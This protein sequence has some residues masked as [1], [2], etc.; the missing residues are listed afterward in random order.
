[1]DLLMLSQISYL[2]ISILSLIR[3]YYISSHSLLD[4]I[5]HPI[6]LLNLYYLTITTYITTINI[7]IITI[8][9]TLSL[10]IVISITI[11]LYSLLLLSTISIYLSYYLILLLLIPLLTQSIHTIL[12]L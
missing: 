4:S 5:S 2:L 1:M 11:T 10:I 6:Q 7:T 8:I 3:T 9:I 12:S